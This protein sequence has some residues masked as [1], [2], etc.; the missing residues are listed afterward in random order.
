M[1]KVFK[2]I[3]TPIYYVNGDPHIGHAYTTIAT[4]VLSRY[5]RKCGDDVFFLTGTDEH[6]AKI[7]AAAEKAGKKPQEFVDE[8]SQKYKSLWKKLNISYSQFFRTTDPGHEKIVQEFISKLQEKGFIEKRKYSGLY[9]IGCEKYLSEEELVGGKCPD[10]KTVPVEQSEENYFFKLSKFEE[11][12][13]KIIEK[14]EL[15]I[16]PETRRNEILGKLR[17]GLEDIS[18]SRSSVQWG[19]P[20][21]GDESQTIY[22]WVDALINYYSATEIF[23]TTD[24]EKHPADIHLMAKDILWFHAVIWPAM[25]LA[26]F[27]NDVSKL[28]KKVFAHGFFTVGGEKMS[29]SRGNVINPV[30]IIEKYGA[31]TIRYTLLREFPFGADGDI[32]EEKIKLR[33]DRDLANELGNLLQRVL[34]MIKK[35]NIDVIPRCHPEEYSTKDLN[36]NVES[37]HFDSALMQIWDTIHKGNETIDKEK[38]WELAKTD[39]AKLSKV[40]SGEYQRLMV[41]ASALEPFMPDT[42]KEMRRQLENLDPKPLFPRK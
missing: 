12:L 42:A 15:E 28:P 39:T 11:K 20:F 14:K 33:Y 19:I 17:L 37:F 35:Y 40:L 25:L 22:V 3:T 23:K 1:T 24:W 31:D 2:Y 26:Y 8:F 41:I 16:L 7:A 36:S 34:V 18:I 5:Y 21:P 30:D 9:C 13:V 6:G 32:S 29:K 4:D 38:P 27:D 10:H